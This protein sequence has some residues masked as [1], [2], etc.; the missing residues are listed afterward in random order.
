DLAE[1]QRERESAEVQRFIER[2]VGLS[3][4]Q[5]SKRVAPSEEVEASKRPKMIEYKGLETS[6]ASKGKEVEG[7]KLASFWIPS[8]A[9]TAKNTVSDPS[10]LS[11]QCHASSPAHSLKLKHL[12]PVVFRVS[13]K[14]EK[15][16]PSCDK[17]LLNSTKTS[18]LKRCGHA[19]CHRCVTN[20]VLATPAPVCVVCQKKTS[21]A[22]VIRLESEGTGFAGAGGQMVATRYGSALQA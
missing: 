3:Q 18:V 8:L 7:P 6:V 5:A 20:F 2:E 9:P 19:V 16:C 22:D 11:V 4:S 13:T 10:T 21:E 14:G 1:Q 17:P 15:L 12:V